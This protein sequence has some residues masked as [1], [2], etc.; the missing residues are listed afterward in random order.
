MIHKPL[1]PVWFVIG[2]RHPVQRDYLKRLSI[3]L[4]IEIPVG[5]GI[6]YAP[7]LS[8]ARGDVNRRSNRAVNTKNSFHR[9]RCRATPALGHRHPL[10]QLSS[11]VIML[12]VA[13]AYNEHSLAQLSYLG[14][15]PVDT[16]NDDRAR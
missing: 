10:Q 13:L 3:H 1:R 5:G 9:F 7:E 16:L 6:H 12:D 4:N 8:F 15:V 14:N 2:E 11:I